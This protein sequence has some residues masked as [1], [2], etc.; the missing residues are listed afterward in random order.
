MEDEWGQTSWKDKSTG[1]VTWTKPPE[2]DKN[3]TTATEEQQA[4]SLTDG[5]I[6]FEIPQISDDHNETN[7]SSDDESAPIAC[8]SAATFLYVGEKRCCRL[9]QQR[10]RATMAARIAL[11]FLEETA[12]G[13]R[14]RLQAYLVGDEA[15]NDAPAFVDA[16]AL[17]VLA[18]GND[19]WRYISRSERKVGRIRA[20]ATR[21]AFG[22][23]SKVETPATSRCPTK[24]QLPAHLNTQLH[25]ASKDSINQHANTSIEPTILHPPLEH[26]SKPI[27]SDGNIPVDKLRS[28]LETT[29]RPCVGPHA[30][31]LVTI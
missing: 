23:Q 28:C 24:Y 11:A 20:E 13:Y 25:Q 8:D 30:I 5:H 27:L 7:L 18:A 9:E 2:L 26:L 3:T 19:G 12:L 1:N 4:S 16:H 15:E 6:E 14:A 29:V 10:R 22:S 17:R 21:I 31:P